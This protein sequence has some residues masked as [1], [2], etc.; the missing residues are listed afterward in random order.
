M[1]GQY[2]HFSPPTPA[3]PNLDISD[4]PKTIRAMLRNL[5]YLS[6]ESIEP[7]LKKHLDCHYFNELSMDGDWQRNLLQFLDNNEK[8]RSTR[9]ET[10]WQS[11]VETCKNQEAIYTAQQFHNQLNQP[12]GK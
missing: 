5:D 3:A 8:Y 7:L 12:A 1:I 4:N 6:E 9:G 2:T 11:F 10:E